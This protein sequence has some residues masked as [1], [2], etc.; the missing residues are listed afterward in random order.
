MTSPRSRSNVLPSRR[1]V[2]AGIGAA[3][4]LVAVGGRTVLA[5]A[6]PV[7]LRVGVIPILGAAP[8]FVADREGWLK[9]AGLDVSFTTFESGPNMIQAL[10]SGTIDV[11]VAGVAPLI[12]ARSRGIDVRVVTATAV[13]EMTF[14]ATGKLAR[15]FEPGVAPA[16]A[17]KRFRAAA[18]AP[19]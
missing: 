6:A 14:V 12:V 2:L 10:A 16:E 17:F 1:A 3:T 8:I 5:Q 13:E 15:H 4:G 9:A 19:A 11:Y 7:K 18:G